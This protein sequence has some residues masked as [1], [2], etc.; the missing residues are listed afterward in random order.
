MNHCCRVSFQN[1]LGSVLVL[2]SVSSCTMV[3][4]DYQSPD[5]VT[6]DKWHQSLPG[7]TSS[8]RA[9]IQAWWRNYNDSKLNRLIG[10]AEGREP[11]SGTG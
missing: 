8:N 6:P 11:D 2:V 5:T 1:V 7:A 9:E 10:L 3:G 4:P